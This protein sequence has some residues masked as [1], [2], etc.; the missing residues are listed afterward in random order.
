MQW[1]SRP[2][3][4]RESK[5]NKQSNQDL[6]EVKLNNTHTKLVQDGLISYISL[7]KYVIIN[8]FYRVK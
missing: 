8:S 1:Q 2:G 5:E 3:T 6:K 4:G 7:K